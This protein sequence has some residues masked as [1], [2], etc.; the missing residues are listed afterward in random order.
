MEPRR[1]ENKLG[2]LSLPLASGGL[3]VW[4]SGDSILS[5]HSH[6]I[7]K[8]ISSDK[9]LPSSF[10][11]NGHLSTTG[12]TVRHLQKEVTSGRD[13]Q[14]TARVPGITPVKIWVLAKEMCSVCE[15]QFSYILLICTFWSL[16]I[17]LHLKRLNKY[18]KCVLC[19]KNLEL[20]RSQ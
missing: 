18:L 1:V 20:Q 4:S 6:D 3:R 9:A 5:G 12:R 16:H 14:G 11:D 17:I 2:L 15:N 13:M 19:V 8:S 10:P 7:L